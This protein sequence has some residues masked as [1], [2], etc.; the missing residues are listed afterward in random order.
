MVTAEMT[1]RYKKTVALPA[2]VLCRTVAVKKEGGKL[3]VHGVI[4][5]EPG[6][7]NFEAKSLISTEKHGRL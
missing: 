4:E 1:V 5:T 7:E 3:W 2:V 6:A